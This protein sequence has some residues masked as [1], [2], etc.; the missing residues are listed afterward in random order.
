MTSCQDKGYWARSTKKH[1]QRSFSTIFL[2]C[3]VCINLIL[4]ANF[5]SYLKWLLHYQLHVCQQNLGPLSVYIQYYVCSHYILI[6]YVS[7]NCKHWRLCIR[8]VL[9]VT[10]PCQCL[11]WVCLVSSLPA[12]APVSA[13]WPGSGY[14]GVVQCLFAVTKRVTGLG[15][16]RHGWKGSLL[17]LAAQTCRVQALSSSCWSRLVL[18]GSELALLGWSSTSSIVS[19]SC[20]CTGQ[21]A[22]LHRSVAF[23]VFPFGLAFM[24]RDKLCNPLFW[25][26]CR[27]NVGKRLLK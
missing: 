18:G 15:R 10:F 8:V 1:V 23:H 11:F 17:S 5:F 13:Q 9:L 26:N 7:I 21:T 16:Q 2:L 12:D 25:S 6:G 3:F 27:I 4:F 14:R 20:V 22:A 19:P 24:L